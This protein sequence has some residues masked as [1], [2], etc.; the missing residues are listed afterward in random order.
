MGLSF[1][2]ISSLVRVRSGGLWLLGSV[3]SDVVKFGF[4]PVLL[5]SWA[6]VGLP[7]LCTAG[8]LD[9]PCARQ[10]AGKSNDPCH[11]EDENDD[12]CTHES[13]CVHDPCSELN[14]RTERDEFVADELAGE[15][16][17]CINDPASDSCVLSLSS[18]SAF[19]VLPPQL[20]RTPDICFNIPLLI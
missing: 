3:E 15:H 16:H 18:L 8:A 17:A 1:E 11:S 19:P 4:W 10:E 2:P 7:A 12:G 5:V 9:H 6:L 13:D 20:Q 14:I